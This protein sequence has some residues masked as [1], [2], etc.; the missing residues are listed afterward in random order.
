MM[1]GF[2]RHEFG[3]SGDLGLIKLAEVLGI[4]E[5]TML[6]RYGEWQGL[7]SL[8]LLSHPMAARHRVPP[9]AAR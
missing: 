2:G 5:P 9:L 8:W 1:Y 6:D 3:L 7:A 4:D